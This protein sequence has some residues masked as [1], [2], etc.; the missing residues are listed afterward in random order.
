MNLQ[1]VMRMRHTNDVFHSRNQNDAET[2][3]SFLTAL[4]KPCRYCD[5]CVDSVLCDRIVLGVRHVHTQQMLLRERD[6]MLA[7]TTDICKT[8]EA[9]TAHGK[10]YRADTVN[11]VQSTKHKHTEPVRINAMQMQHRCKFCGSQHGRIKE[12]CPAWSKVC[13]SC[14]KVKLNHFANMCHQAGKNKMHIHRTYRQNR[15]IV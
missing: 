4:T 10:A 14:F 1:L 6:H 12:K 8:A 9:A 11:K 13:K 2:S 7:K 3:E 5:N 15:Y